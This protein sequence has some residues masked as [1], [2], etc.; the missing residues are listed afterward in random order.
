[1]LGLGTP[2]PI[3]TRLPPH[4]CTVFLFGSPF[5]R[6]RATW[7]DIGC[8]CVCMCVCMCVCVCVMCVVTVPMTAGS[9]A[10]I[11]QWQSVSLVN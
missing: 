9:D 4:S 6:R 5:R 1:M 10:S 3:P 2:G 11:A 8:V 7:T